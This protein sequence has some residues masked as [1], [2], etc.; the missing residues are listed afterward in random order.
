MLHRIGLLLAFV[1]LASVPATSQPAFV[2]IQD[3]QTTGNGSA[4][5]RRGDSLYVI[6]VEWSAGVDA[7]VI[8]IEEAS[9]TDYSGTWSQVTTVAWVAAS[10]TEFVH[11][12]PAALAAVRARISTT[13]TNGTV[14]VKVRGMRP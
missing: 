2:T 9:A 11:I 12:G 14:T 8:T 1:M 4:I 7:G 10:S 6:A 3:A 5:D 13:V